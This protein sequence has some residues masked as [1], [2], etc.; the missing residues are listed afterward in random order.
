MNEALEALDQMDG[1]DLVGRRFKIVTKKTG[2]DLFTRGGIVLSGFIGACTSGMLGG[3]IL[4]LQTPIVEWAQNGTRN[5]SDHLEH[6]E[7][8]TW[9]LSIR[10]VS[11]VEHRFLDKKQ[12]PVGELQLL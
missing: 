9:R 7:G 4:M 3:V 1:S 8:T 2:D 10:L 6:V 11:G 5:E 12:C